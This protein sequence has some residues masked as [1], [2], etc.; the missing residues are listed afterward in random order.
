ML[1]LIQNISSLCT[2]SIGHPNYRRGG[3]MQNIG[4]IKDGAIIFSDKIQFVGTTADAHSYIKQH[5][6]Q[7]DN[8]IE[9]SGKTLLP[10][11]CD[12]H[13]HV[14]FAGDR[15]DEYARRLRGATYQEIAAEGGGILRTVTATRNASE[16]E[17]ASNGTRLALSALTYGTTSMEIKSGYS[18][19]LEGELKQLRAIARIKE[20]LPMNIR[21][22][23]LAAHDFPP[24]Y[25][26]DGKVDKQGYIDYI[27]REMLPAVAKE[28]L[29]D[30]CDAFID[31]GYYT[32]E[33]ARQIFDA[34]KRY[35]ISIKT[36]SDELADV[37]AAAFSADIGA[38]SADHLLR[39][40]DAGIAKLADSNTVATLLPATAY[41][42]RAAYAPARK[43]IDGGCI[44]ALATD[45]NPGSSMTEN[46][47]LVLSLSVQ[48]MG[49]TCEEALTA[50]T[51]NGAYAMG[52]SDWT[53]SLAVGKNADFIV[54]NSGSWTDIF[55]HFGVNH[56]SQ[57]WC[58]GKRKFF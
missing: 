32:N 37:S 34:A 17:L 50:A 35:G 57:V 49:M 53:G 33:D 22:T 6:L 52:I 12:S 24:E 51:I 21:S 5:N 8:T 46:M 39:I 48:N 43:I 31:E 44:V 18:L 55:Y 19:N 4:E 38:V 54:T 36:H 41:F 47:Q 40:S 16:G 3:E 56:V 9:A 11:F 30:Y 1:N 58:S 23:F 42:L 20:N 28:H 2:L 27:I 13:T 45:C 15:S 29:A 10:G 25:K 26:S 7:I 14:V